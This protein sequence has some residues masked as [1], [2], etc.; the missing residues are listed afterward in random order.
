[1]TRTF[2]RFF[3]ILVGILAVVLAAGMVISFAQDD[4]TAVWSEI[5]LNDTYDLG[6]EFRIPDRT[7]TV[8]GV[9][10][11]ADAVLIYPDR[12]AT[13]SDAVVLSSTGRYSIKYT[14]D[15]GRKPYEKEEEF[16]VYCGVLQYGANTRVSY[17]VPETA[18][19][20]GLLVNLAAGE[21]LTF[22]QY[23]D[24]AD[25]TVDDTFCEF[26]IYPNQRGVADFDAIVFTLTDVEN[27]DVYLR[28]RA[29]RYIDHDGFAYFSAGGNGQPLV[30]YEAAADKVH[31]NNQWGL[32][33][34]LAFEA[35]SYNMNTGALS[36]RAS[37]Y[38]KANLRFDPESFAVYCTDGSD[39]SS[40]N[41][42]VDLNDPKFF[43]SLWQGFQSGK[44]IFSVSGEGFRSDNAN[45]CFT[46][47]TGTDLTQYTQ[48]YVDR[49]APVIEID[50][51]GELPEGRIGRAYP[52]PSATARDIYAGECDVQTS[53]WYNYADADRR[54]LIDLENG[55]AVLPSEG[56]Y[57]VIYEA[58][59]HAGNTAR[60]ILWLH[61]GASI[62]AIEADPLPDVTAALGQWTE[63]PSLTNLRG[64]SGKLTVQIHVSLGDDSYPVETGFRFE[65]AG[66]WRVTYTVTDYTGETETF[67]YTVHA[68]PGSEPVLLEDPVMP[69]YLISGVSYTIP[70]LYAG[71]YSSGQLEEKLFDVVVTD[72]NGQ[73]TY[74]AGQPFVPEVAATGDKVSL[75]YQIGGTELAKLEI[76]AVI[77]WDEDGGLLLEKYFLGSGFTVEKSDS[78]YLFSL[79]GTAAAWTFINPIAAEGLSLRLATVAGGGNYEKLIFTLTDAEN[80]ENSVCAELQQ[81]DGRLYFSVQGGTPMGFAYT[82]GEDREITVGF[83]QGSFVFDDVPF[84]VAETVSGG[85]FAG[86]SSGKVYLT[87]EAEGVSGTAAYRVITLNG[88]TFTTSTRDRIA[89]SIVITQDY[90]GTYA[91][92]SNYTIGAAIASD[93]LSPGVEFYLTVYDGSNNIVT[94]VNG[95]RLE[96]ADPTG[97]YTFRI[98]S[99]GQYRVEYT[100]QETSD[101]VPRPNTARLTYAINV[102]DSEAPVF[103]FE[104][105]FRTEAAVGDVYVI[106]SFSVSDNVTPEEQITVTTY[107]IDPNGALTALSDGQN[108][109]TCTY[110]GVYE[111]RM[112]AW[113]AEGN[114]KTVQVYVTVAA[115]EAEV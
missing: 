50:F 15:F 94:D 64:G 98:D 71:D 48:P 74:S 8:G 61:A 11:E 93:V 56:Y 30:G 104:K 107:V 35:R 100:A 4:G 52:I 91:V 99:Y 63:I 81:T 88:Q 16:Q 51:D 95:V 24:V 6:T 77:V 101:F 26:Y 109:F 22:T 2:R 105:G 87:V 46:S 44:A 47:V 28:I 103:T 108:A 45:I 32:A 12:T 1:M 42:I 114:T 97:T 21:T 13:V 84:A 72:Q 23:I 27:P 82:F 37:D 17:G 49:E 115:A 89:P 40:A 38:F 14:A 90:G 62:D 53:V 102:E 67:G 7:V 41:M 60:E 20:E 85:T 73:K 65:Q 79:S 9:E 58:T 25:L 54:V 76:P 80:S 92:G 18:S 33:T 29:H 112:R 96:N 36:D 70:E 34:L 113:D 111:I 5:Q 78:G 31:V 57:A 110:E 55:A 59:D 19:T 3:G 39:A 83:S 68:E 69:R 86:F 106:P 10:K 66:E 43:D 75:S